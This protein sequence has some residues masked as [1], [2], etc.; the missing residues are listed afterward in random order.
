MILKSSFGQEIDLKKISIVCNKSGR[1]A[2]KIACMLEKLL[3]MYGHDFAR[4]NVQ[5][6]ASDFDKSA[7]FAISIGGDGTLLRTARFYSQYNVPVL[8][9]NLGHLGFLAQIGQKQLKSGLDEII[10]GNFILQDRIMLDAY[11]EKNSENVSA[12]NDIVI[13]GCEI[14][15]TTRLKVAINGQEVCDYM[16]DGIIISTPTGSSAYNLSA[17]G[18]IISPQIDAIAITPICPHTLSVRPLII[19]G[20]EKIQIKTANNNGYVCITADGQDNF[21]L[22]NGEKINI[23]KSDKTAKLVLI[24]SE[25]N[26]FYSVLRKKLNWGLSTLKR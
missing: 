26:N 6:K 2:E 9:I 24:N 23:R 15:R 22:A 10:N 20:N 13:K 14:S 21:R 11:S 1:N 17:G 19:S 8:G 3:S 12:L 7:T 4:H 16:A 18:A 25:E 5:D